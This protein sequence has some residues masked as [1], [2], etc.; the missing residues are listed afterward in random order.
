[1]TP[2]VACTYPAG[3]FGELDANVTGLLAAQENNTVPFSL[4]NDTA[5]EFYVTG[6]PGPDDSSVRSLEHGVAAHHR[7]EPVHRQ[8]PRRSPTTSPTRPR[9]PSCTS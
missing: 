1:M 8:P 5:P 4:E 9:K 3:S 2:D 7:G 6:N